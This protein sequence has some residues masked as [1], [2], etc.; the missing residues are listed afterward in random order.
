MFIV[1]VLFRSR[2]FPSPSHSSPLPKPNLVHITTLAALLVAFHAQ[3]SKCP[4]RLQALVEEPEGANGALSV[5]ILPHT[6]SN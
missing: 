6:S 3:V 4:R 1:T 5:K 2:S